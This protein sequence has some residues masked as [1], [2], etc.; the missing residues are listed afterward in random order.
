MSEEVVRV[1]TIGTFDLFHIGHLRLLQRCRR[2]SPDVVVGVNSDAFVQDYKG[3]LPVQTEKQRMDFIKTLGY[4]PY[5]NNGAGHDF[6]L[7]FASGHRGTILVIGTDW[8]RKDYL[9]QIETSAEELEDWNISLMYVP[10]TEG[11]ST[12]EIKRRVSEQ[13]N[14]A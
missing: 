4:K 2:L 12:T 9:K 14:A 7:T 1:I 11:V 5:L 10:Y 3:S 13:K 8:L 6:L